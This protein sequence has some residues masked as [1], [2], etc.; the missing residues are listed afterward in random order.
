MK[1]IFILLFFNCLT[2]AQSGTVVYDAIPKKIDTSNLKASDDLT[3]DS[4]IKNMF[5][6]MEKSHF[7]TTLIFN[8]EKSF[9]T[10]P[11]DINESEIEIGEKLNRILL[12]YQ[13]TYTIIKDSATYSLKENFMVKDKIIDDWVISTETKQIDNFKCYKATRVEKLKNRKNEESEITTTAWF[14]PELPYSYGPTN[15]SGL[16]GL[17][18]ELEFRGYKYVAKKITLSKEII[19]IEL[20]KKKV[21]SKEEYSK[22]LKASSQ[23]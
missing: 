6:E 7:S 2:Y 20:P 14:S 12:K 17:I 9:F 16:P 22:K 10:I 21:I 18:L 23:F 3:T 4:D 19:V 15:Y 13:P 1:S 11:N 8:Q 5:H